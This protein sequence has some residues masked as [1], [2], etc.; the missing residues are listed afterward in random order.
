MLDKIFAFVSI[1]GLI[2]FIGFISIRVMEPDL[3][4]VTLV[5][6]GMAV[7]FFWKEIEQGGSHFEDKH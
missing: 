5:V 7:L 6:N 1:I 3:W 4:L 2:A